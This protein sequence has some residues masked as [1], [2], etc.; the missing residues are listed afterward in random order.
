[1]K[2]QETSRSNK[3]YFENLCTCPFF[4][5]WEKSK[6]TSC[7]LPLVAGHHFR[8][9]NEFQK[10][11]NCTELQCSWQCSAIYQSEHH[12]TV[13]YIAQIVP[14]VFYLNAN[15]SK[16]H[17]VKLYLDTIILMTLCTLS[18]CPVNQVFLTFSL[19]TIKTKASWNLA[20]YFEII[21]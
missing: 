3:I 6:Q 15:S 10:T 21:N 5:Y 4:L 14:V 17:T 7:N 8:L 19:F 18:K 16:Y 1:M 9:T 2:R 12:L 11:V 13:F 20:G